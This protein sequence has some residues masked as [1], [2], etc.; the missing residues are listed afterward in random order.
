MPNKQNANQSR[1]EIERRLKRYEYVSMSQLARIKY[2]KEYHDQSNVGCEELKSLLKVTSC[3]VVNI[4]RVPYLAN[5]DSTYYFVVDWKWH[6]DDGHITKY[7]VSGCDSYAQ[8]GSYF[9]GH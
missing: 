4:R 3:P 8:G 7:C 9:P 5:M 2:A 1:Q 6:A